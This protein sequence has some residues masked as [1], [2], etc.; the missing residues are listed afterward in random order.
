MLPETVVH[1]NRIVYTSNHKMRYC[2]FMNESLLNGP[3]SQ[4]AQLTISISM[5]QCKIDFLISKKY[6]SLDFSSLSHCIEKIELAFAKKKNKTKKKR[7]RLKIVFGSLVVINQWLAEIFVPILFDRSVTAQRKYRET[8]WKI[9]C[10]C[11]SL[12]QKYSFANFFHFAEFT[13]AD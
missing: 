7:T 11:G 1:S 12:C 13:V 5:W 3:N 10:E 6:H 8:Y 4:V 2:L 9:C